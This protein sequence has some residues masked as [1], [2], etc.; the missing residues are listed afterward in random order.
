MVVVNLFYSLRERLFTCRLNISVV[1]VKKSVFVD[2]HLH[3]SRENMHCTEL[4]GECYF[5][6]FT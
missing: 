4:L 5:N 6:Y 2:V 3:H 1:I